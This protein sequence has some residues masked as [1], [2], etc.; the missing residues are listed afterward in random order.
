VVGLA[1]IALALLTAFGFT[2]APVRTVHD[3]G[4]ILYT[5]GSVVVLV[6][7]VALLAA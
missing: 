4:Y 6:G 2:D 3:I 7:A 1:G 5:L